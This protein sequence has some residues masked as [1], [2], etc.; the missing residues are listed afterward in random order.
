MLEPYR[1]IADLPFDAHGW[2]NNPRQ[3]EAVLKARRPRIVVEIGS[4][5][6]ASTRFIASHL[7]N[8]SHVY[9]IDTWKGSPNEPVQMKD[10]RL[11]YLYQLFLSN[12]KHAQLTD[13][14]VPMRMTS[15]EAAE[16]LNVKADLIYIDGAHD[17]PSVNKD[18]IYWFPHLTE[19]GMMCGDDW[20]WPSVKAAVIKCAD[21]LNK[22]VC[23][24]EKFWWFE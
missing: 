23:T 8:G 20:T 3:L 2:F 19:N 24:D 5:L 7:E 16:A 4:W 18:I 15:E 10:P 6:G 9:A 17:T 14:I 12:V 22:K 1:S 13:K 21:F 11:P